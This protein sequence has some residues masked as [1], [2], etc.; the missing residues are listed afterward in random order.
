M[1]L[2]A[3]PFYPPGVTPTW[4]NQMPE[5]LDLICD[6]DRMSNLREEHDLHFWREDPSIVHELMEASGMCEADPELTAII[7]EY[8]QLEES[9]STWIEI[10]F[11]W[12]GLHWCKTDKLW[13]RQYELDKSLHL[14]VPQE[15]GSD[16]LDVYDEYLS[17]LIPERR[18]NS[19]VNLHRFLATPHEFRGQVWGQDWV[20]NA[21][22]TYHDEIITESADTISTDLECD[23]ITRFC[24]DR[25]KDPVFI[26]TD[27]PA[28]KRGY[29]T[30]ICDFGKVYIPEKFRG[31]IPSPGESITMTLAIQ[32]ASS[33]K[34]C[35]LTCIYI[36]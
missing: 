26:K 2:S 18:K 27:F 22:Q 4:L 24:K 10:G 9:N 14:D 36:H 33:K 1:S 29:A 30:G 25:I 13:N 17:S 6:P 5:D 15:P 32:D 19:E 20:S 35:R 7:S 23:S 11:S 21:G 28:N 16:I 8:N 31:Y 34:G 3:T 12:K